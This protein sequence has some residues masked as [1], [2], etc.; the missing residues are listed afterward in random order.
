LTDIDIRTIR[1]ET[2]HQTFDVVTLRAVERFEAILPAAASLVAPTGR[3]AL[4]IGTSQRAH[5]HS[6]PTFTW[7]PALPVPHSSS[8]VLLIGTRRPHP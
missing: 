4:L 7:Q 6:L 3:L 8:R 1:A 5:A 2:L